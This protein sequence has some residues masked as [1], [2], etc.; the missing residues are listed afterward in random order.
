MHAYI[1]PYSGK[2]KSMNHANKVEHRRRL[3]KLYGNA[4][5]W[6]PCPVGWSAYAPFD[7][8][9]PGSTRAHADDAYLKRYYRSRYAKYARVMSNRKVRRTRNVPQHCGYRRVFDFWW[10]I[11]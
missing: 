6:Y 2:T 5:D 4:G 11:Y 7:W 9:N 3:E 8:T 10:E 1:D